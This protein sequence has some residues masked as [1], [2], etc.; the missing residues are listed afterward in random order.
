MCA[1]VFAFD[2]VCVANAEFALV[3]ERELFLLLDSRSLSLSGRSLTLGQPLAQRC[4]CRARLI[5]LECTR[6]VQ[7]VQIAKGYDQ[8]LIEIEID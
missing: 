7:R 1:F 4:E 3:C 5:Q 6:V 8:R 2:F